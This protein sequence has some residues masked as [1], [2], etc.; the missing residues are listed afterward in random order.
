V[1]DVPAPSDGVVVAIDNLRLATIARLTGAPQVHSAGVALARK[2]GDT[3]TAGEPLYRLHAA[4]AA[5]LEFARRMASQDS[6]YAIGRAEDLPRDL[7]AAGAAA[8][9]PFGGGGDI[10]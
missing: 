8:S 10:A 4:Y 5:D 7:S 1:F 6:G 9:L 2:L 3:V